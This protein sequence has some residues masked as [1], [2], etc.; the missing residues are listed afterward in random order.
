MSNLKN[1]YKYLCTLPIRLRERIVA[2]PWMSPKGSTLIVL[3][4]LTP[5]VPVDSASLLQFHC[6]HQMIITSCEN[7]S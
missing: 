1:N 6:W 2:G 4:L 5:P 7:Q 3:S